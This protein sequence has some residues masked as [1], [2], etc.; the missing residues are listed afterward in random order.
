MDISV[1]QYNIPRLPEVASPSAA[2]EEPFYHILEEPNITDKSQTQCIYSFAR[3]EGVN[4]SNA[5]NS[6]GNY[7]R[8]ESPGVIPHWQGESRSGPVEDYYNYTASA[9]KSREEVAGRREA[10]QGMASGRH[11]SDCVVNTSRDDEDGYSVL[12]AGNKQSIGFNDQKNK[13]AKAYDHVTG[14]LHEDY[15]RIRQGDRNIVIGSDY[16]HVM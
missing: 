14:N 7:N 10:T 8:T 15:D 12:C 2:D 3:S 9:D 4:S 1:Y 11:D 6:E 16:D 5:D 13:S